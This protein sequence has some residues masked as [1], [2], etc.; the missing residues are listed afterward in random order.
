MGEFLT[1]A[2]EMPVKMP[3]VRPGGNTESSVRSTFRF[4]PLTRGEKRMML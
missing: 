3:C 4:T 2:F 1:P